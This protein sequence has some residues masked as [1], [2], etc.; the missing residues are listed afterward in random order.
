MTSFSKTTLLQ[1]EPFS[2]NVLYYQSSQLLIPSKVLF[3]LR[4]TNSPTAF[5]DNENEYTKRI[6]Q[7]LGVQR[8]GIDIILFSINHPGDHLRS[9]I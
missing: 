1:R 8:S 4:I 9:A 2:H 7:R 5:N 6:I 3:I